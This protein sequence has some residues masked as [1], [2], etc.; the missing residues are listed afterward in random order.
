MMIVDILI[1][2][3]VVLV[4]FLFAC[5]KIV[6]EY[7][8]AVKF[9]LGRFVGAKGPGIFF[10]IPGL[11][12]F[13]KVDLRT[14]TLDVPKQRIITEDNVTVDVDAVVYLRVVNP[15]D[16]VL[17]VRNYVVATSL[18]AQTTLRDILGQSALDDL[19][20][21]R[22]EINK[23]LQTII[24]EATDA[25]GIK[26][27]AVTI[28][29]VSLPE[30]MLRA[31]A[32]QAEAERERRSRVIIAEG[33]F[34]AAKRMKEAAEQYTETP[35]AL[36]LRELQTLTEIAREKNLIVVTPAQIG[37]VGEVV[38]LVSG[39]KEKVEKSRKT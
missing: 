1:G 20:S 21:K 27:S 33:E 28:R 25:W 29:D 2:L 12:N 4:V 36:R 6:R 31:I 14:I 10:I 8:R 7:E 30:E 34:E 19:L 35:A 38:G 17:K 37:S 16:A 22:D 5:I 9:R 18:L 23:K 15:S 13:I 26:V 24:D 3:V 32:K 39:M 11:E